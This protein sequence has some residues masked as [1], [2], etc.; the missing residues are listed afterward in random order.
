MKKVGIVLIGC[1]LV[2]IGL[3]AAVRVAP[4]I[5][6]EQ[7]LGMTTVH[8]VS[9][10]P[11]EGVHGVLM[12]EQGGENPLLRGQTPWRVSL[13][14][15][16]YSYV[17]TAPGYRSTGGRTRVSPDQPNIAVEIPALKP[18]A[19]KIVVRS[20]AP[21]QVRVDGVVV[22]QAGPNP[23][24]GAS[25]GPFPAG[26]HIV[27]ATTTLDTR[28]HTVEVREGRASEVEFLWGSR[29]TVVLQPPDV[30]SVAVHVDGQPYTGPMDMDADRLGTRPFVQI[31][32][33]APGYK[34]WAEDVFP[35]PGAVTTVS[36]A[37]QPVTIPP[38]PAETPSP[39]PEETPSPTPAETPSPTPER[40]NASTRDISPRE[41]PV[42]VAYWNFWRVWNEAGRTL[43]AARLAEVMTGKYLETWQDAFETGR[44][45][46][47]MD[48]FGIAP[49]LHIP[50]F[51]ALT[52]AFA[53][54][55][56]QCVVTRTTHKGHEVRTRVVDVD[57]DFFMRRG[58]DGV[59]RVADWK[60]DWLSRRT[61]TPTPEPGGGRGRW[62][63]PA[64]PNRE[65]IIPILMANVNCIRA[66]SGLPPVEYDWELAAVVQPIADAATAYTSACGWL[67]WLDN[68]AQIESAIW[69]YGGRFLDEQDLPL[70]LVPSKARVG[71]FAYD[72]ENYDGDPYPP[73]AAGWG[74]NIIS[75][76]LKPWMTRVAIVLGPAEWFGPYYLTVLIAVG[77]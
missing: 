18:L 44:A 14:P 1:I 13:S 26:P 6:G 37:L 60:G 42:L 69:P 54:L 58:K 35:I 51:S 59:W 24:L 11:A 28:G 12:P 31:S 48:S 45:L 76:W 39:T 49:S 33:S 52:D 61:P 30:S 19:G 25:F 64:P 50:V 56:V 29:L 68:I 67:C 20:N 2:V 77:R 17:A 23:A 16:D 75:V 5:F 38:T 41:A 53:K 32:V 43:D 9:T 62:T 63:R 8:F 10:S 73:C 72:W 70:S 27:S 4:L 36:V 40:T 55:H 3:V 46:G 71:A 57:G 7:A 47:A 34:P 21:A 22:G 65:K 74:Q 15:G 66:A